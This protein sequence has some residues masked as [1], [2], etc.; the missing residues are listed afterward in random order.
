MVEISEELFGK[1][2]V[3]PIATFNTLSTKVALRDIGKV[4][5]E[6]EES[7][8]FG[9]LPY[10]LRDEVTK[11]IPTIKTLNDLGESVEKE[12]LL[13][14]ILN[15]NPRLM[16]IYEEFP[17]WF[18]YVMELEGLPKSMGRHAAGTLITPR[19]VVEYCPLCLDKEGNQMCQLEMHAA[20]DD[21]GLTKMDYLGLE[22]LDTIDDTLHMAGLTWQQVDINHL[23]LADEA[24]FQNVYQCGNTVGVFQMES[25]DARRMCIE[26]NADNIEDI[27]VVNAA[28]R[29]G[30][31]DSFPT[32]CFNKLHPDKV[33]LIHPSL[34]NIFGKTQYILLY[35][36]QALSM[37]RYAG[38]PETEVDNARRAIGKK[39]QDVMEELEIQ[40]RSG[41][42]AKGWAEA[43]IN[44][45]WAL[46]LKQASYSF[47]RGHSVA[48][49]LLSYLTAWLKTH[50][51]IPFMA[52]CLAAK[53][54]DTGKI[55]VFISECARMGIHVKPPSVNRSAHTF[56]PVPEKRQI[57]F[58]LDAIKGLGAQAAQ[59]I[60]QNRPYS[61]FEEFLSK[62]ESSH[63]SVRMVV[64]LIKAGAIPT[65]NKR[66]FLFRYADMLFLSDYKERPFREMSTLPTLS[67][68]KEEWGIDGAVVKSKAERLRLYNAARKA[69]YDSEKLQRAIE[70]EKRRNAFRADFE[71]KYM[72]DEHMWEFDTL[73]MFLTHNPLKN[74]AKHIAQT[75]EETQ[76]GQC[77]VLLAV[78][79]DVQR[80]KDKN[81]RPY[82]YLHL[83]TS[84]GITEVACWPSQY[85][86]YQPLIKKGNDVAIFCRKKNADSIEVKQMKPYTQW[87]SDKH[88]Q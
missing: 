67:V 43:Q 3:A 87:L 71:E 85:K 50:Y 17:L 19:P 10:T 63:L 66:D 13:K 37:F 60:I 30:T 29:P 2:N 39:K 65:N 41:L 20:M 59:S 48:Y 28:N 8:Y 69:K 57:L 75:L 55:G 18:K 1:E 56:L 24:V 14:D 73:S 31:K 52:A 9:K 86:Q 53:T 46:I 78:I 33:S 82:A 88:I 12:A 76:D 70:K 47:N 16:Q 35:Q 81:G 77:V 45:I 27:I 79:V 40:F 64:S 83:Y 74:A 5:N 42:S 68:L 44:E 36:E 32:Y 23:N 15:S 72:Q 54:E 26:A 61:S 38:F 4:L 84:E 51:P 49:G 34:R 22:T 21:L 6:K 7:P 62:N 11:L 80:K 25:L 58:G